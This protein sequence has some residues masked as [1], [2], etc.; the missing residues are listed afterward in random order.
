[1]KAYIDGHAYLSG[2]AWRL[3]VRMSRADTAL[4]LILLAVGLQRG[5]QRASG[6][7]IKCRNVNLGNSSPGD[8]PGRSGGDRSHG[9]ILVERRVVADDTTYRVMWTSLDLDGP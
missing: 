8:N 1:M 6:A 2:A 5:N 7:Q 4:I 9:M 3:K